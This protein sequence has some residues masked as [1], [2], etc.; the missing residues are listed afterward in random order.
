MTA[1]GGTRFTCQ[2][3]V[4]FYW[5]MLFAV[6][7][8][9]LPH[10]YV[11]ALNDKTF[12]IWLA[13]ILT[14]ISG[15]CISVGR[16]FSRSKAK[17]LMARDFPRV[18][19]DL[20][21]SFVPLDLAVASFGIVVFLSSL[22]SSWRKASFTGEKCWNV[23]GLLLMALCGLYFYCSRSLKREKL[24][25]VL[26]LFSGLVVTI[27]GILNDLSVAPAFL[28]ADMDPLWYRNYTS[29][30]GNVNTYC[31]WLAM[32]LPIL[33]VWFVGSKNSLTRLLVTIGLFLCY[34]N[35]FLT[36][37]D[38]LYFS[39]GLTLLATAVWCTKS[40]KRLVG[41]IINMGLLGLTGCVAAL[42]VRLHTDLYLDEITPRLL[43]FHL[44]LLILLCSIA[45]TAGYLYAAI[46]Y[47]DKRR[48]KLLH[49]LFLG[50]LGIFGI[51]LLII[52]A[53][54]VSHFDRDFLN[55][56]GLL[57]EI[58]FR[59]FLEGGFREKLFGLGPGNIDE[60]ALTYRHLIV[61]H[62]DGIYQIE[63]AHNDLMEY[64]ATTGLLGFCAYGAIYVTVTVDIVRRLIARK[65]ISVRLVWAYA[66]L[67]GYM[68]QSFLN[69]PHP[70][71]TATFFALLSLYRAETGDRSG[72][73][74][75]TI[76]RER[77]WKPKQKETA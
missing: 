48:K 6:A 68:T 17:H 20:S 31:G 29:T 51:G 73:A 10:G 2:D 18:I 37:A 36:H 77:R 9:Y 40:E 55:R 56:R 47:S 54:L 25:W 69:G 65:K 64:L 1:N 14:G 16:L 41:W 58:A 13:V 71:T 59:A 27:F 70:L 21:H 19:S 5:I 61:R 49:G 30:I 53:Y 43:K 24:P 11:R 34:L 44:P 67:F 66:G 75:D 52:L 39:A 38:S 7:P 4:K 60:F 22:L 26:F 72:E 35:L 46:R 74:V 62:Y 33:I 23:G 8:I 32:L 12:I 45:A 3:A 63:N 42:M 57:W 15:G 28:T 50:S 76:K